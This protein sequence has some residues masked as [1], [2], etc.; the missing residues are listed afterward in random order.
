M[1]SARSNGDT[2]KA[3]QLLQKMSGIG[4]IDLLDYKIS[5][6]DYEHTNR[7][8]DFISLMKSVV[9]VYDTILLATPVYWYTMSGIMKMFLD[10]FSDLLSIEKALGR[11]LKGKKLG[12][13]SCSVGSL[14]PT[15]FYEPFEL[16]ALYLGMRYAGTI[17][18]SDL[19][20]RTVL[21]QFCK[22]INI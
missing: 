8:D 10:R 21:E 3:V 7:N 2:F 6:Y 9:E 1:G 17:H 13:L 12:V 14:C 5:Q 19:N 20:D 16:S 18:I 4:S 15:H 11:K 22:R